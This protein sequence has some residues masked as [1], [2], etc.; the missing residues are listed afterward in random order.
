MGQGMAKL[1]LWD[2]AT[3]V[4][5]TASITSSEI[6]LGYSSGH[7]SLLI[8]LAGSSP[9]VDITL[10][11]STK[12]GETFYTPYDGD[13]TDLGTIT[14]AL[15]ATRWIQFDPVVAHSMKIVVTGTASNGADTTVQA[16]LVT[17]AS[18]RGW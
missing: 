17:E 10:T 1:D 12:S 11:V 9:E 5:A 8:V 2:T 3:T 4:N 18:R 15:S 14:S 16:Y 13:G 7:M 6:P